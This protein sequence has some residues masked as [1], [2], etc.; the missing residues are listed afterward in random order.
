[1]KNFLTTEV[2]L[3]TDEHYDVRFHTHSCVYI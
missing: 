1:M 2:R 3:Y